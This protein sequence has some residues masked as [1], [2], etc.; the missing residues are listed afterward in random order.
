[1]TRFER[2][3]LWW[4]TLVVALT[5]LAFAYFKYLVP[6]PDEFAVVNHPL[7]PVVLKL[8][9]VTAPVLVFALGQ[10]ATRHIGARLRAAQPHARR[11]GVI[12][13]LVL[14]PMVVT[15][16]LLQVFTNAGLLTALAWS[17]LG[18]G[19]VFALAA[20]VHRWRGARRRFAVTGVTRFH[21]DPR[22]HRGWVG[23]RPGRAPARRS[24]RTDT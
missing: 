22:S 8:H 2:L 10:I 5:G 18:L 15:G 17:H 12:A 23:G 14:V 20:A 19:T 16:Y 24:S 6:P 4:S 9:I 21:R 13:A 11:S 3:L 1:M 7:Q